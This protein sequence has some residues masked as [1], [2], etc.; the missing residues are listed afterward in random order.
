MIRN[1]R[2]AADIAGPRGARNGRLAAALGVL[3]LSA[4]AAWGGAG[5]GDFPLGTHYYSTAEA[6]RDYRGPRPVV[7]LALNDST[8]AMPRERDLLDHAV[9]PA[10]APEGEPGAAA[11]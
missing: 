1:P 8:A 9:A 4:T 2:P 5:P 10:R 3:G 7:L 6:P 11:S